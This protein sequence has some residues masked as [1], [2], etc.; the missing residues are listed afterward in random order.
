MS[1]LQY[2]KKQEKS[3]LFSKDSVPD[4]TGP[5]SEKAPLKA[6]VEAKKAKLL[7]KPIKFVKWTLP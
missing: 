5:L 7:E 3:S 1:I 6:I 4:P 2:F